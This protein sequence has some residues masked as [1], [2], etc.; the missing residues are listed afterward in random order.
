MFN[1]KRFKLA[2]QIRRLTGKSL[3]EKAGLTPVTISKIEN[4]HAPEK[5]T[6]ERLVKALGF[7][8]SFFVMDDPE[9]LDSEAVSFR[10]LSKMNAKERDA[11]LAAGGLGIELYNWI[12]D[13]FNLPEVDL[14]DLNKERNRPETAARMLR[15]H[16]QL[17]DRPIGNMLKLLESKGIRILSLS[18][19][20]KNVDAYSFWH[21]NSAYI[22]LN[23]EKTAERS[24]F[25][26]AH[27]LAHLVLH[28]HAGAKNDRG[29]EMQADRFASAFLMPEADIRSNVRHNVITAT[30]VIK[31]KFRWRV[32]AMAL[33]YRLHA[34]EL[35]SDWRY[36]S[37]CIE[38][39]QRGYRSGEPKGVKRETSVV[40]EKVFRALWLKQFT[41][42]DLTEELSFPLND[43]ENLIFKLSVVNEVS[44]SEEAVEG[45]RLVN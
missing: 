44:Q 36:R 2:K 6:I 37:L 17:G 9:L 13:K 40:L 8:K 31:L 25:D 35:L 30:E 43:L 32:S 29:A 33:A 38:L 10:S 4:G 20:T 18:E 7:P 27:E 26:S 1:I 22:F 45:L 12:N 3:A 34:L 24:I 21:S 41:K 28:H 19:S 23:Q 15:Q 14:I 5:E 11:S 42:E 39:G 16:W